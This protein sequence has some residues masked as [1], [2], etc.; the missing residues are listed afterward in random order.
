MQKCRNWIVLSFI[1]S[2]AVS[3]VSNEK[4]IYLQNLKDNKKI[5]DEELIAYDIPEYKLQFIDIID[6]NIQTVDDKIKNGFNAQGG[7]VNNQMGNVAGALK[8][9]K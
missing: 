6:V 2:F 7:M 9:K 4:I 8:I 1:F 3:C 5:E